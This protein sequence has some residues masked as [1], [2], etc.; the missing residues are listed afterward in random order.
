M[1]QSI[2][3]RLLA[4]AALAAGVL[5]GCNESGGEAIIFVSRDT[6]TSI[7]ATG[8]VFVAERW[9]VF[10]A[11][12]FTTGA[13]G[14]DLNGDGDTTD[15]V[16]RLIE[17]AT[18]TETG[19]GVAAEDFAILGESSSAHV[20]LVV[21][22][23]ADDND[24]SGDGAADDL[25][26]LHVPASGASHAGLTYLCDL[27]AGS[28]QALIAAGDRVWFVEE[29]AV[30]SELV[31]GESAL[32]WIDLAEPQTLNRAAH[33]INDPGT[34]VPLVEALQS[35]S[36]LAHDSGL[37]FFTMDETVEAATIAGAAGVNLNGGFTDPELLDDVDATDLFVLGVLEADATAPT[38]RG[39]G[40]AVASADAPVRALDLGSD[41]LLIAFLA[42]ETDQGGDNFNA[43]DAPDLPASGWLPGQCTVEDA[44]ILDNVLH[45]VEYQGFLG[46]P[47]ANRPKNTG[48]AGQSRVLALS[49]SDGDFVATLVGEADAGCDLNDDGDSTDVVFRFAPVGAGTAYETGPDV[50]LAVE[51]VAGGLSGVTDFE[52]R[53]FAVISE[54]GNVDDYNGQTSGTGFQTQDLV[55]WLDPSAAQPTWVFDHNPNTVGVQAAGSDWLDERAE[56][57]FVLST[58]LESVVGQSLNPGG[59][60]T[61][62]TDSVTTFARFQSPTDLDFPGPTVATMPANP[63]TVIANDFGFFRVDEADDGRDW[64]GDGD[65]TDVML[66][67]TDPATQQNTSVLS[68]LNDLPRPAVEAG[69]AIGVGYVASEP[70]SGVDHNG[71]GDEADLVLR[72]FRIG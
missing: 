41:D 60:D 51:P 50:L 21:D 61:D 14:T 3:T 72:W 44:D 53:F 26:L 47:D 64:N 63:G 6:K 1:N 34:G 33:E 13:S 49:A 45:Y 11:D 16:A 18:Q 29:P 9:I 38:A 57:D 66:F 70:M 12:E 55:A 22:E 52:Q 65:E 59:G 28:A 40:Y 43:S 48:L 8:K 42:S 62:T 54:A 17:M 58:F 69:G 46:D 31:A 10:Q 4:C 23:L 67:R 71:D 15:G 19:L 7:G 68:V 5:S 39:L 32:A 24:W 36:L 56:R 37:L 20:Y 30:G 35:P 25:V 27:D 2:R